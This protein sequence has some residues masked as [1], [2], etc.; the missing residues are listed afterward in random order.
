MSDV[1]GSCNFFMSRWAKSIIKQKNSLKQTPE[2][3]HFIFFV[4]F[5]EL[6]QFSCS[7]QLAIEKLEWKYW[8]HKKLCNVKEWQLQLN[9]ASV[10]NYF[11]NKHFHTHWWFLHITM[12]WKGKLS[13]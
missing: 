11:A 3:T 5:I 12:D 9:S 13:I 10:Q 6:H 7:Q 8:M 4:V 1:N 2:C